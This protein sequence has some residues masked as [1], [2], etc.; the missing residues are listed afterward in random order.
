MSNSIAYSDITSVYIHVLPLIKGVI[1]TRADSCL[2][3]LYHNNIQ[4]S[5]IMQIL[6]ACDMTHTKCYHY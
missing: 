3:Q 5:L 2:D 6:I 1:K 4:G